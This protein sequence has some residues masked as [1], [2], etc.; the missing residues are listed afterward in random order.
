MHG[1][2]EVAHG[3]QSLDIPKAHPNPFSEPLDELVRWAGFSRC[4]GR[5]RLSVAWSSDVWEQSGPH[6]M[7]GL[8]NQMLWPQC[9]PH[10]VMATQQSLS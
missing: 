1:I 8:K 4:I 3:T 9:L 6:R 10:A 5:T 7:A 2:P